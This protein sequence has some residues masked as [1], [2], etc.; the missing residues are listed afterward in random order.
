MFWHGQDG[1]D[2]MR[3]GY[4][5]N[6]YPAAS[7]T[8]I[9]R[10]IRALER[11]G[12]DIHRF[13]VRPAMGQLIDADDLEEAG[14]TRHI[15]SQGSL[16][17]LVDCLK[18][19]VGVPGDVL[20]ASRI[21][22]RLA[23][24]AGHIY[25]LHLVYLLEAMVLASWC[26]RERIEHL[27][28]H[29]GTNSATVA[30]LAHHMSRVPFSLTIHGPEEFDRPEKLFLSDKMASADFTVAVSSFGRS[31]LQRWANLEHWERIHVV[32]C[33]LDEAYLDAEPCDPGLPG[34][35]VCIG[36]LSEQKGHLILLEAAARLHRE[37]VTFKLVLI[38][39]GPLRRNIE[40]RILTL[41]LT[42]VVQLLGTLPQDQVRDELMKARALVLPSLAEGLPVV[43]M[44]SMAL[45]RPVISTY[46]AG[47]P[48]LVRP[49]CGWLVPAGDVDGLTDAM[50]TAISLDDQRIGLMGQAGH[51]R[52]R[53]RHDIA[54]SVEMLERHM[55]NAVASSMASIPAQQLSLE[56]EPF[57][58]P[59]VSEKIS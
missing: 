27:H 22:F 33:G 30:L 55:R 42:E 11:R 23:R 37:G 29:F 40:N 12:H 28:V 57:A 1:S 24:K 44:E 19:A 39:D 20:R 59:D 16:S 15:L 43:L 41:G 48:E 21:A 7:H 9:R 49:D 46:I 52:V 26:R 36:R 50:R 25:G 13:A 5:T 51:D 45:R 35:L 38:G 32:P 8:F 2:G 34:R 54:R 31:Q 6:Q 18:T 4:F 14:R 47:I 10:E 58:R 53:Q 17:L 3:I 56:T